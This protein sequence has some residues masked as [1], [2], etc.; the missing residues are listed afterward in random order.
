[1]SEWRPIEHAPKDGTPVWL[2]T[3]VMML[4]LSTEELEKMPYV[5]LLA[6]FDSW[7][8]E[9]RLAQTGKKIG[10]PEYQYPLLWHPCAIPAVPK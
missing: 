10:L 8:Y 3:K 9:W 5:V 2:A 6:R 7:N 1:M 4:G